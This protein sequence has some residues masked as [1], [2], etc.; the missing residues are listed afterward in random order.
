MPLRTAMP[1]RTPPEPPTAHSQLHQMLEAYAADRQ[2]ARALEVLAQLAD[3]EPVAERRARIHHAAAMIARDELADSAR[4]IDQLGAAL[5]ADPRTAG[6]FEA[7]DELWIGRGDGQRASGYR[8]QIERLGD[9]APAAEL[10]ALW[11]KLGEICLELADPEAAIAAYQVAVELLPG[12]A[13]RREQLAELCLAGGESRRRIAIAELQH[14]LGQ[15]PDRTEL[16]KALS[17]LYRAEG[18]LDHAWCVAQVL[19]F[20][21]AASEDEHR[22]H[23]RLRPG[24]FAPA[25]R[26][27]TDELWHRSIVHPR[28]DRRVS[29][30]LAAVIPVLAADTAQPLAAFGLSPEG[31]VDL[32]REPSAIGQTLR[33][34]SSVLAIEP[35]P[36]WF[37]A[38]TV[39]LRIANT[40]G[41]TE[42]DRARSVPSVIAGMP[43][44]VST[45]ERALAFEVGKRLAYV[46]PERF[47][48][49]AFA[50]LPRLEAA[51]A[52]A[53]WA[54]AGR[55]AE[56]PGAESDRDIARLAARVRAQVPGVVLEQVGELA[57]A[58]RGGGPS[59]DRPGARGGDGRIA[60]WRAATDLTANRVGFVLAGD[61]ETAARGIATEGPALSGLTVKDRLR[62][63]LGYAASESYFAIR[64]H[65]GQQLTGG[66]GQPGAPDASIAEP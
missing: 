38:S 14:L 2:W 31:R 61:L 8:R 60:A 45:A 28:E 57:A 30:I 27:L 64:R 18:A 46:R 10:A 16:Y 66:A 7:L 4:A 25:T 22:L 1:H 48:A 3:Q 53:V 20:L 12:D 42:R 35:P 52:A 6:A 37:D 15:A 32:E 44:L 55:S 51:F 11:S 54:G 34:A 19:V 26:R 58:L 33:Q 59:E 21:G 41:A 24:R 62:D 43:Q 5:D 65:L 63:L 17:E 49:L 39:G 23:T 13:A 40:L 56:P 9:A 29:A 47:A 50:T 36:V